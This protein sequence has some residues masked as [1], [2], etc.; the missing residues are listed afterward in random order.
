ML[1][2]SSDEREKLLGEGSKSN[3][4]VLVLDGLYS[5][6]ASFEIR[7]INMHFRLL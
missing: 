2:D 4:Q 1:L 3:G 5:T 6:L 7:V